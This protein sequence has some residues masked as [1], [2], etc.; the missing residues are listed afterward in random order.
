MRQLRAWSIYGAVLATVGAVALAVQTGE[1]PLS[2]VPSVDNAGPAGFKALFDYL[3]ESGRNVA[4]HREP[5]TRIPPETR[6]LVIADPSARTLEDDE[7]EALKAFVHSGGTVVYLPTRPIQREQAALSSFLRI[8]E[9]P[10]TL[11]ESDAFHSTGTEVLL[12]AGL[13]K[14]VRALNMGLEPPLAVN[15]EG[16]I[17]LARGALFR[18]PWGQ[19]ELWMASSSQLGE[20]RRIEALDNLRFWENLAAR[21]PVL[22]DEYHHRAAEE[23]QLPLSMLAFAAQF[24]LVG[25]AFVASRAPRL[26]PARAQPEIRH[27]SSLEYAR[28]LANLHR[29]AGVEASLLADQLHQ[30]RLR[31]QERLGVPLSASAEE[32]SLELARHLRLPA[33]ELAATLE[34]AVNAPSR[35]SPEAFAS[36]SRELVRLERLLAGRSVE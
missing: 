13:T 28:S 22:F 17:P 8:S 35:L 16:A 18:V 7:V 20:N 3:R 33:K 12:E 26:A 32:L 14:E 4:A 2:P 15:A 11:A 31:I 10:P 6:A 36:L 21:G 23:E 24:L 19:G 1:A 5:L 30:L 29:G 25:L 34:R 27:R 9:R